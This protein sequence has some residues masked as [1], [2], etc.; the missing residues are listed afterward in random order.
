MTKAL[1]MDVCDSVCRTALQLYKDNYIQACRTT[2]K[3]VCSNDPIDFIRWAASP[4]SVPMLMGVDRPVML[5]VFMLK[6]YAAVDEYNARMARKGGS[7]CGWKMLCGV[8]AINNAMDMQ[9]AARNI[10]DVVDN[11]YVMR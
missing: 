3:A 7:T 10:L 6:V 8:Q 11:G 5:A 4:D 1:R 9:C 2:L